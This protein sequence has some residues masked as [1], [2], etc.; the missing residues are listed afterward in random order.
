[1]LRGGSNPSDSVRQRAIVDDAI[2]FFWW[3]LWTISDFLVS[4]LNSC[5]AKTRR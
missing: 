1:M 3:S 2:P 5:L 4:T